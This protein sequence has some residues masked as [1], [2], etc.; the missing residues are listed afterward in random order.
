[1]IY[2]YAIVDRPELHIS[3][4]DGLEDVPVCLIGYNDI[5]AI[6]SPIS[7][8]KV[9]TTE[10][11]L[12][13]HEAVMDTLMAERTLLPVRFGTILADEGSVQNILAAHYSDFA[14]D[15]DRVRGHVELALRV[16]WDDF[17]TDALVRDVDPTIAA[18]RYEVSPG[19]QYMVAKLK[20]YRTRR[21]QRERAEKYAGIIHSA[22]SD[23]VTQSTHRL[24]PTPRVLMTAAYLVNTG[25]VTNFLRK[26]EDLR[27]SHST[28]RFLCTGPWPPFTFVAEEECD[29]GKNNSW[30]DVLAVGLGRLG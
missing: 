7:A 13:R 14:A 17:G 18:S 11:N 10:D 4:I 27:V 12:W 30:S 22:L 6:V 20:E 24:L 25:E 15:L 29:Y 23:L 21:R 26:L 28:L 16:C 2:V 9:Q 3:D 5:G 19:G 8:D 1:M